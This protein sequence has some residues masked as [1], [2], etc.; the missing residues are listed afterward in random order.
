MKRS[1]VSKYDSKQNTIMG[2]F[3]NC[4]EIQYT[5]IHH[6][7]YVNCYQKLVIDSCDNFSFGKFWYLY[8]VS[9]K[10]H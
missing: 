1:N 4:K 5:P 9:F 7:L 3:V 8:C 10:V 6:V 2:Q